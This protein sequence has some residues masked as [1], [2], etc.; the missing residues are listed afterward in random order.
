MCH[1]FIPFNLKMKFESVLYEYSLVQKMRWK[2]LVA[3]VAEAQI[4]L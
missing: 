2:L 1:S 3:V 4:L